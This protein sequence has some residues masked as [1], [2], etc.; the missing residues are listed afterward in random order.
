M[1]AGPKV[2]VTL[3]DITDNTEEFYGSTVTVSGEVNEVLGPRS[4]T[5]GGEEFGGEELLVV[6]SVPRPDPEEGDVVQVTGEVQRFDVSSVERN[7]GFDLDGELLAPWESTPSIVADSASLTPRTRAAGENVPV[8][9][10]DL[11]DDSSEFYGR[12]VTVDGFVA[13]TVEPSVFFLGDK[14]AREDEEEPADEGGV[15]VVG[16]DPDL[17]LVEAMPVQVVG[18]FQEFDLATFEEELGTDLEDGLYDDWDG[19]PA[20]LAAEVEQTG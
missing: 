15:L 13:E 16:G 6:S 5:I 17:N 7:I 1:S 2:G 14:L 10:S 4:F 19:R 20:I 3:Y 8:T 18:V 11:A 12:T 9:L